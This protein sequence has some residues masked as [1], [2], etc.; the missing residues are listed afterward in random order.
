MRGVVH[1]GVPAAR[2]GWAHEMQFRAGMA[3]TQ[4]LAGATAF[5]PK[6]HSLTVLRAAVQSCRGCSLYEHATQA[7]FGEGPA[8]ARLVMVGE[9][10]GDQEDRQGRPFVGPAG[11]LLDEALVAAGIDRKTVYLTNAV[12]HFKY[13]Q[14]G[15]RRIHDKPTRYEVTACRPWLGE[16]LA[17]VKPD[18]VVILGATAGQALLG[19]AFRVT[20]AR[21]AAFQTE[22][23][24]WTFATVHPAAVLRAFDEESRA[25]ARAEFLADLARVGEQL[26]ALDAAG[27]QHHARR[28]HAP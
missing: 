1:C 15:K 19:P 24:P 9:V 7:V 22:L 25:A 12:K 21:G 6:R 16:E 3:T 2:R 11:H 13:T 17:A 8:H 23:A 10:P 28:R 14:R 20:K 27:D 4:A 26:R 5:L 18:I